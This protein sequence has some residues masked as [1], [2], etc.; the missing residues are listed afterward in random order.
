MKSIAKRIHRAIFTITLICIVVMVAS[1]LLVNESLEDAML[2]VEIT[3]DQNFFL[4]HQKDSTPVV[5]A[6]PNLVIA[7]LPKDAPLPADMPKVFAGLPTTYSGEIELGDRTFLVRVQPSKAGI[8]YIAKNITHFED[9]AAWFQIAL[10]VV[11]LAIVGL[12]L[13][14]TVLVS[15]RIVRPLQSLSNQISGIPAGSS[16]SRISQDFDDQEL[17]SI[18]ETFNR[19]LDELESFVKREQSLLNLASHELRT[20]IA[21]ISGAVDVLEQRNQLSESDRATVARIR[22]S[23]AEMG[24]NVNMLLALARRDAAGLHDRQVLDMSQLVG[25]V[26]EDLGAGHDVL[27]RVTQET[28]ARLQVHADATIVRMLL[29]NLIQN[30]LQHT[31]QQIQVR[32]RADSVEIADWGTGLTAD[33]RAV[34]SGGRQLGQDGSSLNGLGLYIVTLMCERL[35]WRLE[36]AQNSSSGTTICVHIPRTQPA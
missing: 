33:Q 8:L 17:H 5:W 24:A 32:I 12:S 18:A 34:L 2:Q 35:G 30:A 20:P 36:V 21:V 1:T 14:L 9:R 29:R 23:C 3:E 26:L 31:K 19:F 22:S 4:A 11:I 6:T 25:S 16:M 7:H 27:H 28:D 10:S 13:L 15:R